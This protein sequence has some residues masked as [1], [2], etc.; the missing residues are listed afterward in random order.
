MQIHVPGETKG[1]VTRRRATSN[2]E[3][4]QEEIVAEEWY[5]DLLSCRWMQKAEAKS[6]KYLKE[7]SVEVSFYPGRNN[8]ED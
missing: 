7:E 5:A 3:A 8:R 6:G 2:A 4:I 1:K